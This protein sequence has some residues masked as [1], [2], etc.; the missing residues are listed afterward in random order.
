MQFLILFFVLYCLILKQSDH[1]LFIGTW[2]H[3]S[4]WLFKNKLVFLTTYLGICI[5]QKSLEEPVSHPMWACGQLLKLTVQTTLP[6][7]APPARRKT[8]APRFSTTQCSIYFCHPVGWYCI[9]TLRT[10]PAKHFPKLATCTSSFW[11]G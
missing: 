3:S 8:V 9:R 2:R 10:R 6:P 5:P 4:L 1:L 11:H 7:A